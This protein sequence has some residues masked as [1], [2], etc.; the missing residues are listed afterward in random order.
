M[1]ETA[2]SFDGT[3][4]ESW[5][6]D[7]ERPSADVKRFREPLRR[8][9]ETCLERRLRCP[10]QMLARAGDVEHIH[11]CIEAPA[12]NIGPLHAPPE[13]RFDPRE[14]LVETVAPAR[15][16]IEDTGLAAVKRRFEQGVGNVAGIEIVAHDFS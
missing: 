15:A 13:Q 2:V 10:A 16:D 12:C 8:A 11:R 6:I 3:G 5:A 4:D 7:P 1:T 9:S 14:Q